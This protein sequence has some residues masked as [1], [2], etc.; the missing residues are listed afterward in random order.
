MNGEHRT[1]AGAQFPP[2]DQ[3]ARSHVPT[4]QAAYYLGRRAQTLRAWSCGEDGP[5]RPI[6]VSGRLAWSVAQ[7]RELLGVR[8]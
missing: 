2:L 3:E 6:K 7:I 4:E 8:A 1:G 5:L